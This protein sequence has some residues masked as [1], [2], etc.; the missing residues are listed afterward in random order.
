MFQNAP[1]PA[2]SMSPIHSSSY[3]PNLEADFCKDYSCC[4]LLLPNLHDLLRHYEE[5]HIAQNSNDHSGIQ[6]AHNHHG[7]GSGIGAMGMNDQP[8]RRR[9]ENF[10]TVETNDVFNMNRSLHHNNALGNDL[11]HD[12]TFANN[13]HLGGNHDHAIV[14]DIDMMDTDDFDMDNGNTIHEDVTRHIQ[15]DEEENNVCIDDPSRHLYIFEKDELNKPFKCPV[16]GCD[17]TYKNQNGLKYHKLHGHQ[18]QQLHQN[19]DGTFSIITPSIELEKDKPFRCEVC[20]KRYK[21]LNGLK[22]HRAHSTH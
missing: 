11:L 7:N 1:A 8:I 14:D 3:L 12:G 13:Q 10:E 22:Y 16:I 15:Q 4:G 9:L 5:A 17:K 20:G 6:S 2:L 21:N 19:E 18:N